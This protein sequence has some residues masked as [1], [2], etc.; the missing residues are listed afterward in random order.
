MQSGGQPHTAYV[1]CEAPCGDSHLFGEHT[2]FLFACTPKSTSRRQII[3]FIIR[4]SLLTTTTL[5]PSD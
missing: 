3:R 2:P 5:R 1:R 4:H